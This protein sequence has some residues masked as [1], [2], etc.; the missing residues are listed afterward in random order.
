MTPYVLYHGAFSRE[1]LSR[2]RR[3]DKSTCS[4]ERLFSSGLVPDVSCNPS[5]RRVVIA[6]RDILCRVATKITDSYQ[7]SCILALSITNDDFIEPPQYARS[8]RLKSSSR[9]P[10]R[11]PSSSLSSSAQNNYPTSQNI[12]SPNRRHQISMISY[13]VSLIARFNSQ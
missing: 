9:F 7:S 12:S 8:Q 3:G 11:A 6:P 4:R 10:T 5:P 13:S 1:P 2:E